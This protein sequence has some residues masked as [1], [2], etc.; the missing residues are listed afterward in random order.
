MKFELKEVE[1]AKT[2]RF[3]IEVEYEHGDS[4]VHNRILT[5]LES[6]DFQDLEKYIVRFEEIQKIVEDERSGGKDF[7]EYFK[8]QFKKDLNLSVDGLDV[9]IELER[10]VC[11]SE[12]FADYFADMSITSLFFYDENDKKFEVLWQ[13]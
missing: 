13:E 2:P 12:E 7:P 4:E 8:K 1:K 3:E 11:C 6:G 10:D 9:K 5:V